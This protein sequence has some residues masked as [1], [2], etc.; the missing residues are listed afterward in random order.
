MAEKKKSKRLEELRAMNTEEQNSALE[1]ARRSI[2]QIR[3]EK[4]SKPQQNVK[5]TQGHRLEIARILT[6][7]RE[8]ELHQDR[9]A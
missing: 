6:L 7:Q 9:K 3:R 4:L 2:Y 5:A 8:R 1:A